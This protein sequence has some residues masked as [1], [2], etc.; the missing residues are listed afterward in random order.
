MPPDDLESWFAALPAEAF[1]AA[2]SHTESHQHA[3]STHL[4]KATPDPLALEWCNES[5]QEVQGLADADVDKAQPMPCTA[6]QL[7][8][9]TRC[10]VVQS[11]GIKPDADT[12]AYCPSFLP[13]AGVTVGCCW[14]WRVSLDDGRLVWYMATPA[15]SQR[16]VIEWARPRFGR[17]LV[18]ILPVPGA[19]AA[20]QQPSHC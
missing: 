7:A 14:L 4:V 6:C 3:A 17:Q 18:S 8:S 5:A 16:S 15:A 13:H 19:M 20:P 11:L 9:T 1:Q 2:V 10:P 12:A